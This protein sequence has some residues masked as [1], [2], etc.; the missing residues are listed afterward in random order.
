MH[1]LT[2]LANSLCKRIDDDKFHKPGNKAI[3]IFVYAVCN[4]EKNKLCL[5]AAKLQINMVFYTWFIFLY[6]EWVL[7]L[8][9]KKT[10]YGW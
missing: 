2:W 1:Q 6:Y 5:Q 8:S 7:I 4:E 3:C 10:Q 9:T